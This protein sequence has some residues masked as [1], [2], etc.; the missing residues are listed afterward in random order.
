[1]TQIACDNAVVMHRCSYAGCA[2]INRLRWLLNE[3]KVWA[4]AVCDRKIMFKSAGTT[5]WGNRSRWNLSKAKFSH[6][7]VQVQQNVALQKSLQDSSPKNEHSVI[8]YSPS[9]CSLPTWLIENKQNVQ[10]KSHT[11]LYKT[12]V[13]TFY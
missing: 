7:E 2:T 11:V 9:F 13:W 12:R 1:M 10:Q 5:V 4:Q 8:I 6:R 3:M